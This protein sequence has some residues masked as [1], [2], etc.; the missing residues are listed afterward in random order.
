MSGP[1]LEI[2]ENR[3]KDSD[4]TNRRNTDSHWYAKMGL[5]RGTL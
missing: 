5:S 1:L 4:N 2:V 3:L